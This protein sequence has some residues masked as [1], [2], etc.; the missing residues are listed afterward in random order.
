MVKEEG[1]EN[2]L[3]ER[4]AKDPRFGLSKEEILAHLDPADYIGRS[5]EQVERFIKEEVDP[6]LARTDAV[7]GA[8]L[9][10]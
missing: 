10:V 8:A 2:D 6:I 9:E 7:G 5:P 4:I 1:L 3:L